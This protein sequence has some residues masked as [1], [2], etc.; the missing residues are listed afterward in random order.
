M[1][2]ILKRF[3]GSRSFYK[4]VL[5][6]LVPIIIQQFI[7]SFVSL[8]DNVMVGSLGTEAISAAS[9][10]NQ[11]MMVYNLAIF[12]GL[13]GVSI[14]GAQYYGKG[15]M[16]G[17]RNTFRI[18][19][20]FA[21]GSSVL[22][23]AVYLLAGESF[24]ASFLMG[25]SNGGDMGLALR[26]GVEYLRIMLLGLP[27]FALVQVYAGTLRASG[28]PVAPMNAGIIAILT[29]LVL[30]WVLI[31]GNLGFPAMGVAGAAIATI[32]S[33]YAELAIVVLHTHHHEDKYPFIAGAYRNF[34]VPGQLV[35]RVAR[36]A[37]PLLV[38]EILWSLGMTFINQFYSSRGLNAVAALNITG[39]AWNLFCVIMFAMG[40]AVSIM[41]GQRL[42]A[43]QMAEARDVDRKL[44][45]LTEVIHVVIG[46][47]MILASPMVPK[48]YN[49]GDDVRSLTQQLLV[50]AGL[51]LPIHSF[52]HVTY[53]T[54]RSGGR[55]VITFFF[56]AV[57]TWA[58]TVLLA[59]CLTRFTD[60]DIIRI[61]FC[62]QFIDILKLVI[63]LIMLRSDFWARN[64]VNDL[65]A[66]AE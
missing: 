37:M 6:L 51:A 15:D 66:E 18:K 30:N 63:G 26:E 44:I 61:Y 35:G 23:I 13:S 43:G 22:A 50:I 38:N 49:V 10:A 7:S 27:P 41:V 3:V 25:E 62:V 1:N 21:V 48:L 45:F 55:T 64:V 9:I 11:V 8:L 31:F 39:T 2:R 24:I 16:D 47:V 29:N 17:M 53:F 12:G 57:Y 34:R 65:P 42:G 54:I 36:T 5:T 19:I 52:A 59:F 4:S 60:L 46:L 28:E 56:D 32:I 40:S 20:S 33:R 14:F 58:V